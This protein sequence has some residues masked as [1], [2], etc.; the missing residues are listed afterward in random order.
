VAVGEMPLG[1]DPAAF[2]RTGNATVS[3][4]ERIFFIFMGDN[5]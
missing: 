4:M 1:I 2:V 3:S 5:L